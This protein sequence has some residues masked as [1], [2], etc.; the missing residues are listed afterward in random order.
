[1]L[2]RDKMDSIQARKCLLCSLVKEEVKTEGCWEIRS[3]GAEQDRKLCA[4]SVYEKDSVLS[5]CA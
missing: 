3:H 1:M 5:G 4:E 2:E